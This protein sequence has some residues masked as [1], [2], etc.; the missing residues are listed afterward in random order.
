MIAGVRAGESR[1]LVLRGEAGGGKSALLEDLAG[2]AQGFTLARAAGIESELGLACAGLHQ[3][4][5]PFMGRLDRLPLPQRTALNTAF[6]RADGGA[7]DRFLVGLAL[8]TLL[9]DVA[10]ERPLLCVVDDAHWLD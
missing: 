1:A 6:G 10:E 8:L 4:C 2:R 3:L 5:A 7:P 9:A